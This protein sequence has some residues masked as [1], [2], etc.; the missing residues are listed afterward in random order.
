MRLTARQALEELRTVIGVLREVSGEGSATPP[1]PQPTLADIPRLVEDTRQ[2][3]EHISLDM[4]VDQA[5]AVPGALARDAYRIVQEA[6]TNMRKHASGSEA[7]VGVT[8][9]PGHGVHITVRNTDP[10]R[11]Q[12]GPTLP[13]SGAGL[14]GLQ[15][16]VDLAG[17]SLVHGTDGSGNFVVQADLPW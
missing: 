5:D 15:E 7:H 6:L 2:T 10:M 11:G 3:G 4:R 13:G 16:R 8:G 17:G 12:S 1:L 14:L 9:A